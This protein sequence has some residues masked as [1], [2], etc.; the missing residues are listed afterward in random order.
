VPWKE[1]YTSSDERSLSDADVHWPD[2]K[3][4]CV[5]VVVDLSLA[6]DPEGLK[7]S[8]F[9]NS[10]A[11]FGLTEGLDQILETFSR[12][13]INA[14][15]TVPGAMAEHLSPTLQALHADGCEIAAN[16]FKHEDVSNLEPEEERRR[17][18][19]ATEILTDVIGTRPEGWFS[20]PRPNDRYAGGT[21][22]PNTLRLISDAGYSYLGNGL[23]DDIP[24]Y[25]VTDFDK[26][27][28]LLTMPYYYHFDDQFFLL[29]PKKG[30][31][32]EHADTLF[33]NWV[34]EFKAQHKRGRFFNMTL[35]PYAIGWCNRLKLLEDF[36][37]IMNDHDGVWNPTSKACAAYWSEA[38]PASSTL[39]LEPSIWKDYPG[40]LS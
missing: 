3:K 24:Y 10:T 20:L 15:F 17:M 16:G 34:A 31:G 1:G 6:M 30:T 32:L 39:Q 19:L 38:Y 2:G 35:H 13:N 28:S 27:Q 25:W 8:D 14:T 11:E 29:F 22:S 7:A 23:S 37:R 4:C 12:F 9:Q 18:D 5:S 26:S 36:F 21:F 40:S 33:A